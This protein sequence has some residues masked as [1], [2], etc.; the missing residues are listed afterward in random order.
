MNTNTAAQEKTFQDRDDSILKQLG[1]KAL[2]ALDVGFGQFSKV[3]DKPVHDPSNFEWT[4]LLEDNWTDIRDEVDEI[5]RYRDVLPNF[6]DITEDASTISQDDDWKTF[7][8]Y[9]YG[10]KAEENCARCPRTTE[11]IEQVPG[12]TTAFFSILSPGK[13][14][15]SHRGPYKGV[16]RYHLG[17]KVPDRAERCRIRVDDQT[18]HWKEGESMMF[19]DTYNH[20]V[21][22]ETDQERA[23][24][25]LDVKRPMHQPMAGLNDLLLNLL[26]YTPVVQNAR[27]NQKQWSERLENAER[28]DSRSPA[29]TAGV[30]DPI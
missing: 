6:Q 9:G 30:P 10:V 14:I 16:L 11:L 18:L 24:L 29:Q 20:E 1:H 13:H 2:H 27:E 7:F 23:I 25:F 5:L 26:Q 15:P 28:E 3:G 19:D 12:M 4:R 8:L 21:R 17:L 22:N